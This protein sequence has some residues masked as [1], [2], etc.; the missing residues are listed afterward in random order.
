MATIIDRGENIEL[1]LSVREKI[2]ALHGNLIASKSEIISRKIIENPWRAGI[3]KGIRAPGTAIPFYLLLGTMRY[4]GGKD[5]TII[6]RDK[7]VEVI[8]FKSGP[9]SRWIIT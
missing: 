1:C 9:Y 6:Y 8:E 4:K 7:P 5:F 3:L 2:A